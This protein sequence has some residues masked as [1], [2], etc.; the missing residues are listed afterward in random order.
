[1]PAY[2]SSNIQNFAW[3]K[4]AAL[5]LYG[6]IMDHGEGVWEDKEFSLSVFPLTSLSPSPPLP[7]LALAI[8]LL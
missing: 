2:Y 1:M 6:Y 4:I 8:S 5:A 7:F 3:S